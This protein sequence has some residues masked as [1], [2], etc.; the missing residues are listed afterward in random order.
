VSISSELLSQVQSWLAQDPDPVTHAEL[1]KLVANS[2]T[3]TDALRELEDA[4]SAPLEFG[5]AGL[6]GPLGPGPVSYT[7][8]TLPTID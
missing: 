7:H 3:D 4:F 2:N 5:T 6:R 8:L 1:T